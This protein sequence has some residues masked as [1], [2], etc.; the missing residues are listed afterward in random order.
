MNS[1]N[2]NSGWRKTVSH[3]KISLMKKWGKESVSSTN[4]VS[5]VEL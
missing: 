5:N 2:K 3:E 4:T 1:N